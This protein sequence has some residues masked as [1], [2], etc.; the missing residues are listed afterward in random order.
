[1]DAINYWPSLNSIRPL[2]FLLLYFPMSALPMPYSCAHSLAG[3]LWDIPRFC[4]ADLLCVLYTCLKSRVLFLLR[5][6]RHLQSRHCL[7]G[8]IRSHSL[9]HRTPNDHDHLPSLPVASPQVPLRQVMIRGNCKYGEFS[10]MNDTK[11]IV[12]PRK[13]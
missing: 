13:T 9:L 12:A 3:T 6:S 11:F 10:R 5:I 8:M 4:V 7:M 1:M 2:L